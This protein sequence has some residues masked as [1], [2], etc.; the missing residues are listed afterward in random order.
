MAS[1]VLS[2]LIDP[3]ICQTDGN[4]KVIEIIESILQVE[5]YYM[6]MLPLGDKEENLSSRDEWCLYTRLLAAI[7]RL[8]ED[9][10]RDEQYFNEEI[11][12]CLYRSPDV[13][14]RRSTS[15]AFFP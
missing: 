11:S 10:V 15:N 14:I 7:E 12:V 13:I 8:L 3:S 9:G 1:T 4:T 6:D 2:M 5:E